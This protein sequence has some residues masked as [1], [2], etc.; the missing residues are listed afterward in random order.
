MAFNIQIV[1]DREVIARFAAM[2]EGVRQA[3]KNKVTVLAYKLQA[4]VVSEKLSG[5]VLNRVTGKL[6]RS[7]HNVIDDEGLKVTG[8]VASSGDVKYAARHEFGFTGTE[9]IKAHTRTITQAFGEQLSE[10][11]QVAVRAYSRQ[12][13]TPERSFLRSSLDD[14]REE[15][16]KGLTDAVQKAIKE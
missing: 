4:K 7:I 14:M 9:S 2:P 15:I 6:A 1:G 13:K 12:A 16:I 3:L 10:A 11:K 8:K 5:Q